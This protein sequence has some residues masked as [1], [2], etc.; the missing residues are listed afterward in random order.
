MGPLG[1]GC[2]NNIPVL[3]QVFLRS[4]PAF[5]GF[6][7]SGKN[8][9]DSEDTYKRI[10]SSYLHQ[11]FDEWTS[12]SSD[13]I[14]TDEFKKLL[15]KLF[16][17]KLP[18]LTHP[19]NFI[20]WRDEGCLYNDILNSDGNSRAFMAL[21]H[22]L[23][24]SVGEGDD[25]DEPLHNLLSWLRDNN[26]PAN[27]SKSIPT[28]F[29]CFWAP[30]RH[31]F[32]KP[33][34][35]D[36]FLNSIGEKRL[37]NGKFLSVEEYRRALSIMDALSLELAEWEPR[38][39]IDLQS[40][41]YVT[42]T[43][44]NA[45]ADA[46]EVK[47]P[48][49]DY[50]TEIAS[51][52]EN[53]AVELPLNLIIYGPPGTGKTFLLQNE[54]MPL[55]TTR[56]TQQSR[57][58]FLERLV[59]DLAWWQVIALVLLDLRQ[60]R[61]PQIY[62]HELLRA[63][64]R[65][66]SQ[67]NSRAM[68]WA[69]LQSHT[70]E[71]CPH[72]KYSKRLE[73]LIFSK[74]GEGEWTIDTELVKKELPELLEIRRQIVSFSPQMDEARRHAFITF[75]QSYSYEEFVEGIKPAVGDELESGISYVVAE[76]IF[77]QMV[78][79]A[80]ADPHNSYALFIDEIN[81]ANISK[82]FGELITLLEPDKRMRW[83][84]SVQKWV[85]GAQVKLPYTHSQNAAAPP[86]GV[87]ENLHIIGTMNTAD[88]SIALLDTALRRRFE[89]REIMPD[90]EVFRRTGVADV[91]TP[92]GDVIDLAKLLEAMNDRIEFLFD[93]DHRIGHSYFIGVTT[94]TELERV[95]LTKIIPLLQEYFYDDWEKIQLVFADLA[96]SVDLDGKP[97]ARENAIITYR[98]AKVSSLFG[99]L[100]T[101]LSP[102]RIYEVPVSIEPES[103]IKIYSD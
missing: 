31:I 94:Y 32:I 59:A 45:K 44:L 58:S 42:Q 95:F 34:I 84:D 102:R 70:V 101:Y 80:L 76:G 40:F 77:K 9:L 81:R 1:R 43:N 6:A 46:G 91:T 69:M 66:M 90:P 36:G 29:L 65:I 74:D 20:N 27:M 88:R 61:V 60:A 52:K 73:P 82:V 85:G 96:D 86:F 72:V 19:Q 55:F 30:Q 67:K 16:S 39:M 49:A 83:D 71:D 7:D 68:I 26:C 5:K 92:D 12:S 50:T 22:A 63:K 54:Y 75:H 4:F 21:L 103:I 28:F 13:T 25:F 38:D 10:T 64:D 56:H 17:Y 57:E 41:Y 11:L 78:S 33:Q 51:G 8:Y 23:L 47:E 3:K 99:N 14:S 100:E 48:Q 2:M 35:F 15:N 62:Q 97:K 53:R 18:G 87:P 89:F 93:R 79:R 24:K 98:M 37:G